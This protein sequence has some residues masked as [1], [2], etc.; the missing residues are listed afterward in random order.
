M[1]SQKRITIADI[2]QKAGVSK[3]TV[4]RVI[5]DKP[6]VAP[7]TREQIQGLIKAMGY[8]PDPIARSMKGRSYTLGC[9]TPNFS[10]LN[11]SSI[12]QAAQNTARENGFFTLVTSAETEIDFPS[13]LN[14][15]I[16]RRVDGLLVINPRDDN[17][18]HHLLPHIEN[19]LPIVYI[20]NTPI[21]ESV[22]AICLDDEC[23]GF[24]AAQYLLSLGHTSIVTILGPENEECTQKRLSGF[25]KALRNA[26]IPED[27][28]LIVNGDWSAKS[29]EAAIRKLLGYQVQFSAI[30]AQNDWMAMGAI[31]ALRGSGLKIPDDI[32]VVGYDDLPITAFFDPPLTTIRQPIEQFGI[33]AAEVLINHIR[34]PDKLPEIITLVPNLVIRD[35]CAP[36]SRR[37]N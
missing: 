17:R 25:T 30:C 18:Y 10:D 37:L 23:G 9:I 16:N 20:K 5:N 11:I 14:E 32:S 1:H 35:T 34:K 3:Q 22:S 33:R 15:M 36:F 7:Q 27:P 4:S 8:A 6:D 29:G 31:R 19:G 21:N 26:D 12:V 13:I 24:I 28:R 2:A